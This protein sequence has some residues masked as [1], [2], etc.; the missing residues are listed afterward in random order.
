MVKKTIVSIVFCLCFIFTY[1]AVAVGLDMEAK[2]SILI[3]ANTGRIIYE[4]NADTQL[5]VASTT[6]VLTALLVLENIVRVNYTL[7]KHL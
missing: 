3:D 1:P 6:K 5:T 4:Q 7:M 2:A